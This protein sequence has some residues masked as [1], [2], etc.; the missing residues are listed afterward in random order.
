MTSSEPGT[1]L[2]GAHSS[3]WDGPDPEPDRHTTMAHDKLREILDALPERRLLRLREEVADSP[4]ASTHEIEGIQILRE[5]L[6]QLVNQAMVIDE[7][8]S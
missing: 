5:Q 4:E 1:C 8:S 3:R 2:I 6:L 7:S